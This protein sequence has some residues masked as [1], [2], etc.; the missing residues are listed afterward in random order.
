MSRKTYGDFHQFYSRETLTFISDT[1]PNYK[2]V[3]GPHR[4]LYLIIIA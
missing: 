4:V 3:F 1:A 2:H